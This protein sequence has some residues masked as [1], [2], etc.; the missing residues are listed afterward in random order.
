MT[1]R[2]TLNRNRS[3]IDLSAVIPWVNDSLE[4]I[5]AYGVVHLR[6]D[7]STLSRAS[8]PDSGTGLFFV[9]GPADV[10]TDA[11]GESLVWSHPRRVLLDGTPTVGDEVG[12]TAD[13]WMM[14]SAGS[15]FRVLLQPT[16]GVGV[17]VQSGG[18]SGGEEVEFCVES[19]EGADL[20]V[21]VLSYSKGGGAI[22]PEFD[23]NTCRL[24]ITNNCLAVPESTGTFVGVK[25]Y[26]SYLYDFNV[27][28][29]GYPPVSAAIPSWRIT[30]LCDTGCPSSGSVSSGS[31][32]SSGSGSGSGSGSES[33]SGSGST[34]GSGSG[35]GS[36]GSGLY[37]CEICEWVLID[38]TFDS[39][40]CELTKTWCNRCTGELVT[41][42]PLNP[43]SSV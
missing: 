40:T 12:P 33:G 13:S 21:E 25:G 8:K 37:N 39:A 23:T 41:V 1:D 26:A 20:I 43:T 34:S 4:T 14:S 6:T 35:S 5:P 10:V 9:N 30:S 22:P 18:G 3:Q 27:T 38:V 29:D 19:V 24:T 17:V 11:Y 32:G 42:N 31:S 28:C 36:S 7:F 16:D 15:G 2:H